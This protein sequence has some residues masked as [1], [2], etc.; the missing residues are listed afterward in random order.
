VTVNE[1]TPVPFCWIEPLNVSV[2]NVAT[3]V[4]DVE[5]SEPEL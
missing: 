3:A 5:A 1:C 2:A 4:G